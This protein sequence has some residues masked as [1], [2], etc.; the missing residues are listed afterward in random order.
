MATKWKLSLQWKWKQ[1]QIILQCQKNNHI[2]S[3]KKL[4]DMKGNLADKTHTH[5]T[6]THTHTHT[7]H[8]LVPCKENNTLYDIYLLKLSPWWCW[9]HNGIQSSLDYQDVPAKLWHSEVLERCED[10]PSWWPLGGESH[11]PPYLVN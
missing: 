6:H 1:T 3:Y 7:H 2:Q 11:L 5:N 10:C 4:E 9:Q 8:V